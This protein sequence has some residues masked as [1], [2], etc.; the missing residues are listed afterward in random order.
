MTRARPPTSAK[1]IDLDMPKGDYDNEDVVW[2][3]GHDLSDA[4]SRIVGSAELI[5]SGDLTDDQRRLFAG[6]L[7]RKAGRLS[8][9]VNSAVAL[10][11]LETSHRELDLGPVD[12]RSLIERSVVGAG[13]D[14][15]RPIEVRLPADL[16]LASA[17]ADAIHEVLANFLS[18]ARRFSPDGGA[19]SVT[20]RVVADMVEV[21]IQD[22]GI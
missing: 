5:D 20:A 7:L 3:Q 4:L 17:D 2:L 14:G 1:V 13:E 11:R 21:S 15:E 12:L 8:A 16:P 10:Q 9:L 19:I 18:N 6:I 22:H